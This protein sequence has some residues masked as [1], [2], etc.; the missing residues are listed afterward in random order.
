MNS[1]VIMARIVQPPQIRYT[2]DN[3]AIAEMVVEFESLRPDS[4]PSTLK[5]VGWGNLATE[6]EQ[7]HKLGDRVI[8][9]GRLRM[10]VLE[11][12]ERGNRFKEKRAELTAVRIQTLDSDPNWT[13]QTPAASPSNVV[14]MNPQKQAPEPSPEPAY[15]APNPEPVSTSTA[16][17]TP[18]DQDLDD[19]PF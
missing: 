1:C 15:T 4:P 14:P 16:T 17:A 2:Q 19:I 5:V 7:N 9:E 13:P 8:I 10:S 18:D 6:I 12:E 3:L 11:R